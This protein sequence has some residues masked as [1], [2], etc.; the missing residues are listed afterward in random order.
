MKLHINKW[1]SVWWSISAM[2]IIIG[3][4]SMIIS[5]QTT[6]YPLRPSLDFIGGTRL[7]LGRDCSKIESCNKPIDINLVR[8]IVRQQG[9]GESSIQ[10][11]FDNF[12]IFEIQNQENMWGEAPHILQLLNIGIFKSIFFN[13]ERILNTFSLC[14]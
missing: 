5:W 14:P 8:G 1:R 4:V 10:I 12:Q 6:S 2:I 11:I 9:L 13:L 7:L 3:I